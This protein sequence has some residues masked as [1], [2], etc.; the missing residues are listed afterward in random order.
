MSFADELRTA[1]GQLSAADCAK[2]VSPLLSRRTVED[3][4][5]ARRTPPAWAQEWLLTRIKRARARAE[6]RTKGRDAGT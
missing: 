3:W 5:Q 4:M 2:A 1:A 6:R